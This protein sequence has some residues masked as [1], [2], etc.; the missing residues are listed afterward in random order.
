MKKDKQEGITAVLVLT[1]MAVIVLLSAA[2]GA[3][4]E[5]RASKQKIDNHQRDVSV[6]TNQN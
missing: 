1:V 6:E 4:K 3:L 5:I 2:I